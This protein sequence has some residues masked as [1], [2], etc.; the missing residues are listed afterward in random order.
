M[1]MGCSML[2]CAASVAA[3]QVEQLVEMRK[4]VVVEGQRAL[5]NLVNSLHGASACAATIALAMLIEALVIA[6]IYFGHETG[7]IDGLSQPEVAGQLVLQPNACVACVALTG[8]ECRDWGRGSC[9]NG[10]D[11]DQGVIDHKEWGNSTAAT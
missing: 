3:L 7:L 6:V 10:C 2:V 5:E 9:C 8:G 1:V 4:V 11:C